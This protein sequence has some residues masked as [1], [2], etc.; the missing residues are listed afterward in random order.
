[1]GKKMLN[2]GVTV[3]DVERLRGTIYGVGDFRSLTC[4]HRGAGGSLRDVPLGYGTRH[5]R[6]AGGP[7]GLFRALRRC[8]KVYQSFIVISLPHPA[9]RKI[10]LS[11]SR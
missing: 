7:A 2:E 11:L 4:A 3:N 6:A 5:E 9:L 8:H 1:M 10:P